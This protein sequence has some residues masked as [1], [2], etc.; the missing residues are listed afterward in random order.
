MGGNCPFSA[1]RHDT[2]E[3]FGT[4]DQ[5]PRLGSA[6]LSSTQSAAATVVVA[7]LLLGNCCC[8][9]SLDVPCDCDCPLAPTADFADV[10]PPRVESVCE[11]P[12]TAKTGSVFDVSYVAVSSFASPAPTSLALRPCRIRAVLVVS[13]SAT[14][15]AAV[16]SVLALLPPLSCN[17]FFSF[18]DEYIESDFGTEVVV[19][20]V[21]VAD[22]PAPP[23]AVGA[24]VASL[25]LQSFTGD[26]LWARLDWSLAA[27][28]WPWTPRV[29]GL[30]SPLSD[31]D[32][33]EALPPEAS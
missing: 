13:A 3:W 33:D 10:L 24:E 7:T 15:R 20:V 25:L 23:R 27:R 31:V 19:V 5:L 16:E 1:P 12:D 21:V 29:G 4:D 26:R 32:E 11:V 17:D 6:R 28:S 30:L 18:P 8:P 22:L 9:S 2:T 14:C